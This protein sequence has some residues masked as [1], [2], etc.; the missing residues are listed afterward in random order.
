MTVAESVN[1]HAVAAAGRTPDVL[2]AEKAVLGSAIGSRPVAE[3]VTEILPSDDCFAEGTHAAIFAAIRHLAE[4]G[5]TLD[6]ASVLARLVEA[7]RGVWHTGQ[8]GVILGD[9]M[10]HA[11]PAYEAHARTVLA[12]AIRR[13]GLLA[14][15]RAHQLLSED[16][17]GYDMADAA[18][19]IRLMLDEAFAFGSADAG[20]T[21]AADLFASVVERLHSGR[22]PGLVRFPWRDLRDVVPYL[23]PG[24]LITIAARP[25]LGKSVI[26]QDL[27][28]FIGMHEKLPVILFTMEQD[29][30]EVMDRLIAAEASIELD[31]VTSGTMDESDWQRVV[32]ATGN[33]IE[34]KLVIDDS[35][36]ITL[37]HI[38]A[39]L[40]G[41]ARREP[42]QVAIVDYLQLM[43]GMT[44]ENR[45]REVSAA[46]S[47][48]KAIGREFRIPVVMLCQL[49]RGPETRHDKRPYISDARESGA[50]E[51]DSDVAIL[52]HR[53]DHYEQDSARAGEADLIVD[54]NRNGPRSTVTVAFQGHHARFMDL[55]P[56]AWTPS[57]MVEDR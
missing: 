31:K 19:K 3:A 42:A 22:P 17:G 47:G 30:D 32:G 57:H 9:L 46:V 37:S 51:N 52:I 50:V 39:R 2:A 48:L 33:F 43:H 23:R 6:E 49:N 11:T 56:K 12:A 14:L 21:T 34:S 18:D 40:R 53:P 28:R 5:K 38:R 15:R 25:S 24:Q 29:R 44:G 35:P 7:E 20:M 41:M 13:R 16:L 4:F 36:E 55:A 8:A 1:G 45:Q 10:R 27:A 54:K 26:G